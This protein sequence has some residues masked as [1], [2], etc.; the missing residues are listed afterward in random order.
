MKPQRAIDYLDH[1]IGAAEA[2]VSYIH[3]MD[4]AHFETDRRTQQAVL[5]NFMILGEAS[6]QLAQQAPDVI[7]SHPEVPWQSMRGMRN[8]IAHGYF[9]VDLEVVWT[10]IQ[11]ALPALLIQLRPIREGLAGE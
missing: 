11:L 2:A 5:H 1:M 8:R 10:T 3:G 9:E 6:T 7:A 4:R